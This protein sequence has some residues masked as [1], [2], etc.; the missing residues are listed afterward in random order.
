MR[1]SKKSEIQGVDI[2]R[3]LLDISLMQQANLLQQKLGET[4]VHV[5]LWGRSVLTVSIIPASM[6][7][8]YAP[9]EKPVQASM[10]Q[11]YY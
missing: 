8:W 7:T 1:L 6:R 2:Q 11:I 9:R 10:R 3:N 5:K 4:R